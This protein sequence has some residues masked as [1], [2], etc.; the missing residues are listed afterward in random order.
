MH[1]SLSPTP[2][3]LNSNIDGEQQQPPPPHQKPSSAAAALAAAAVAS[4]P[5]A[6]F[7]GGNP[8]LKYEVTY[9]SAAAAAAGNQSLMDGILGCFK[10]FF[11]KNKPAELENKEGEDRNLILYFFSRLPVW[12]RSGQGTK[13]KNSVLYSYSTF[14]FPY[15]VYRVFAK[16][17][18]SHMKNHSPGPRKQAAKKNQPLLR[19]SQGS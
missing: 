14:Q 6:A 5:P 2:N 19:K 11:G 7:G 12:V 9:R 4:S 17:P 3:Q 15:T 10:P 16:E 18:A 13:S 8:A 1:L